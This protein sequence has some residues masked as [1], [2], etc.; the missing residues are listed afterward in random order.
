MQIANTKWKDADKKFDLGSNSLDGAGLSAWELCK[1]LRQHQRKYEAYVWHDKFSSIVTV[2]SFNSPDDP[3]ISE[4]RKL[5]G[6]KMKPHPQTGQEVLVAESFTIPY[7]PP[8]GTRPEKG[9]MFDP[10]PKVIE[11]PHL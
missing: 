8:P 2:G 9:W 6:A 5:F 10:E 1:A 4:L 3:R 11:V 7:N